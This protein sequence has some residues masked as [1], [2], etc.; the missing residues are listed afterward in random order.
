MFR[1]IVL[2]L[3]FISLSLGVLFAILFSSVQKCDISTVYTKAPKNANYNK[4]FRERGLKREKINLDD[5][6][7]G[8]Q[9]YYLENQYLYENVNISCVIL[10]R[11]KKNAFAAKNT[12]AQNCNN[13]ELIYLSNVDEKKKIFPAK[14]TK[15]N[16]SWTLLCRTLSSIKSNYNWYLIIN[17]STFAIL[18]NLRLMLANLDPAKGHYVGHAVKF[19]G[20]TYNMGQAGYVLSKQALHVLKERFANTSCVADITYMNQE[21]LYLGNCYS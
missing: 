7:Y 17:D 14:K 10:V 12:W 13:V 19:W 4:W 1:F 8:S 9:K 3:F 20:T 18:E 16:S 2:I 11:N 15:E 21:D 5:L 6:R